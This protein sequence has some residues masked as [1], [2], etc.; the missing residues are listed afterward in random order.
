VLVAPDVL[1]ADPWNLNV[2]SEIWK[3]ADPPALLVEV[4]LYILKA[5]VVASS[6]ACAAA[7]CVVEYA[8]PTV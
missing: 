1:T 7:A 8:D 2:I 5:P 6:A 3:I 4:N